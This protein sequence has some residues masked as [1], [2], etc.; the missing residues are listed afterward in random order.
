MN[1]FINSSSSR[2]V[3]RFPLMSFSSMACVCLAIALLSAAGSAAAKPEKMKVCHVSSDGK[4]N[5]LVVSPNAYHVGNP[6]HEFDG[7]IDYEPSDIG[8]SG[9][10][11]E[12][13]NGDGIDDGCEPPDN[14]ACP[15][16]DSVDLEIVTADNQST[17]ESCSTIDLPLFMNIAA[18]P[19]IIEGLPAMFFANQSQGIC[20]NIIDGVSVGD[21]QEIE[22]CINLIASRCAAIN[23]AT[24]N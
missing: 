24:A 21:V 10:G 23:T 18:T 6:A 3:F 7:I 19:P 13:S 14:V 1:R 15:C 11:T 2:P 17:D 8:A 20:F 22:S 9:E 12:D 16:F 5:L 4:V